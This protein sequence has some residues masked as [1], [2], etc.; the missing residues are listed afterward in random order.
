MSVILTVY[1]T[2]MHM[3]FANL[4]SILA[5]LIYFAEFALDPSHMETCIIPQG[6]RVASGRD[7]V[8]CLLVS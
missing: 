3:R 6:P 4:L 1:N 2:Y 8:V 7:T 5:L